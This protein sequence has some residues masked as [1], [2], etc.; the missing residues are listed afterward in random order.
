MKWSST[1]VLFPS[2]SHSKC[3]N[4]LTQHVYTYV[5]Q[6]EELN[7]ISALYCTHMLSC[8]FG[9]YYNTT[10]VCPFHNCCDILTNI[11]FLHVETVHKIVNGS[12]LA[13]GYLCK[14]GNYCCE[15][16]KILSTPPHTHSRGSIYMY[17]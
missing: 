17:M 3:S 6:A 10:C 14:W 4:E 2:L 15:G 12:K 8:F 7:S 13:V 1:T 11:I 5:L 16:L 9:L